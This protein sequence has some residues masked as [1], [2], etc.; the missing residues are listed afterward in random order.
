[1]MKPAMDKQDNDNVHV[2]T[3]HII[4][5]AITMSRRGK[6]VFCPIVNCTIDDTFVI[7]LYCDYT[8]NRAYW[9]AQ[10]HANALNAHCQYALLAIYIFFNECK[11]VQIVL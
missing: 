7:I 3:I 5:I 1:M 10:F 2:H 11:E 4:Q 8:Y 6:V 9:I